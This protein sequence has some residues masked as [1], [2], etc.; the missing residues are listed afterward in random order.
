MRQNN[1]FID[2]AIRILLFILVICPSLAPAK[3]KEIP[4][5][6]ENQ[7]EISFLYHKEEIKRISHPSSPYISPYI[8]LY[9]T[10]QYITLY[11]NHTYEYY[12]L[13]YFRTVGGNVKHY[14]YGTWEMDGKYITLN[15]ALNDSLQWEKRWRG[16]GVNTV[17]MVV[18]NHEEIRNARLRLSNDGTRLYLLGRMSGGFFQKHTHRVLKKIDY[19]MHLKDKEPESYEDMMRKISE[20]LEKRSQNQ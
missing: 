6:P 19:V 4:L 15:S 10:S 16:N 14:S 7:E 20:I 9:V 12:A 17:R 13:Y 3:N 2:N 8:T 11:A 18:Y 1:M 5:F